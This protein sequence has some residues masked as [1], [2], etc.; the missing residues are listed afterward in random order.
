MGVFAEA[1]I[2]PLKMGLGLSELLTR[3]VKPEIFARKPA[4]GGKVI[5][6]NHAAFN[7]GHLA[8]YPAR[9]MA[10]MGLDGAGLAPPAGF[11]ELFAAGKECRDDLEGTVY[12]AMDVIMAAYFAGHRGAMEMLRGVDDAVFARPNPREA[13][14][15]RLPTVGATMNFYTSAHIMMHLGQVSTWRRCFGLGPVM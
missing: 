10:V 3:D 1:L 14:R 4:V 6:A 2:A 11:E 13:A 7:F 5:Q 9:W 8:L 15:E 12:P